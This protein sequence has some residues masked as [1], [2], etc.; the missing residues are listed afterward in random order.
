MTLRIEGGHREVRYLTMFRNPY[1]I[2]PIKQQA[3]FGLS[4]CLDLQAESRLQ[5]QARVA[6][7]TSTLERRGP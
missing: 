2:G 7:R 5:V 3:K 6:G 4:Y 1:I